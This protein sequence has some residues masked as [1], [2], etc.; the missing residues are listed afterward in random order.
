MI[1]LRELHRKSRLIF[2]ALDE[3]EA[4]VVEAHYLAGEAETDA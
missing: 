2:V 1:P 3:V 4:A